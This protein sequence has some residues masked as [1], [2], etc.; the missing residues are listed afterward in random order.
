MA[1]PPRDPPDILA[2]ANCQVL[3]QDTNLQSQIAYSPI[4]LGDDVVD[5]WQGAYWMMMNADLLDCVPI[6]EVRTNAPVVSVGSGPS[7]DDHLD[8]LREKQDNL[9]IVAG[10]ST[11][12]KLEEAGIE[13]DFF[14]PIERVDFRYMM[15][16]TP[17]TA[18]FAGLPVVPHE[19]KRCKRKYAVGNFDHLYQWAG[20]Q[21][22]M[23]M[24]GLTTGVA[25]TGVACCLAQKNEPVYLVGHDLVAGHFSG[26]K[27]GGDTPE[28]N[29]MLDCYDGEKRPSCM[30]WLSV[31]D[32]LTEWAKAFPIRNCAKRGGMIPGVEFGTLPAG[33]AQVEIKEVGGSLDAGKRV[34][35]LRSGILAFWDKCNEAV[36]KATKLNEINATN[37]ADEEWRH[38]VMYL[39]RSYFFQFSVCRR[40]GLASDEALL[41][42]S[43][44]AFANIHAGLRGSVLEVQNAA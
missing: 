24:T 39:F 19:H 12:V 15:P 28:A 40:V 35:G 17:T 20:M 3:T 43:K 5:A 18:A 2:L 16:S 7:L 13:A 32:M 31:R 41:K 11:L 21:K 8:E 27:Y 30:T 29:L 9:C 26:Y 22:A 37:M 14:A 4:M 42:W 1:E 33:V 23:I 10:H 34:R 6:T 25:S 38:L 36:Q 44:E